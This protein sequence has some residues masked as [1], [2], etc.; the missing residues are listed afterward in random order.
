MHASNDASVAGVASSY[1]ASDIS[2]SSQYVGLIFTRL[3]MTYIIIRTYAPSKSMMQTRQKMRIPAMQPSFWPI[4]YILYAIYVLDFPPSARSYSMEHHAPAAR[5]LRSVT[6]T[7][8][9]ILRR[10]AQI[11]TRPSRMIAAI[12]EQAR[13]ANRRVV[14]Q[15]VCLSQ[16]CGII[17]CIIQLR[18]SGLP[19]ANTLACSRVVIASVQTLCEGD[20]CRRVGSELELPLRVIMIARFAAGSG[21]SICETSLWVISGTCEVILRLLVSDMNGD[22]SNN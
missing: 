14:K 19:K 9:M 11:V 5:A 3:S 6:R 21:I 18:P 8:I 7:S 15:A 13:I 22:T 20:V 12:V 10:T 2:S 16:R 4:W 17:C 1:H